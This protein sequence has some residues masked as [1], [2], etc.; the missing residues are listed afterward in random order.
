MERW[1]WVEAKTHA[2]I[3]FVLRS[4]S[5]KSAIRRAGTSELTVMVALSRRRQNEGHQDK[6]RSTC[7]ARPTC[8]PHRSA[9]WS[10]FHTAPAQASHCGRPKGLRTGPSMHCLPLCFLLLFLFLFSF[11]FCICAFSFSLYFFYLH[12]LI[13]VLSCTSFKS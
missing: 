7:R 8:K 6:T 2:I 13:Q 1:T 5:K 4:H 11:F 12:L 9:F 10:P 3:L